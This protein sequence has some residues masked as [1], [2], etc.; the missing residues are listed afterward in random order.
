MVGRAVIRTPFPSAGAG[1]ADG[2]SLCTAASRRR[3]R[4]TASGLI[5]T[6][7]SPSASVEQ[8]EGHAARL[9][10]ALAADAE[11]GV[12][13]VDRR[14]ILNWSTQGALAI[15]T[16][17]SSA[18]SSSRSTRSTSS[19]SYGSHG[20]HALDA[21]SPAQGR[22]VHR[23]RGLAQQGL[24]GAGVLLAAGHGRGAVV[25]DD[26]ERLAA[27]VDHVHEGGDPGVEE[28]AVADDADGLVA[29]SGLRALGRR[30]HDL[31]HAVG[32]ADA[33]AHAGAGSAPRCTAAARPWCSSR[34][35]RSR[36]PAAS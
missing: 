35:R 4:C 15:T 26:G 16:E 31:G 29:Q 11:L 17:A 5:S 24:A 13:L 20:G 25:D 28:G 32:H 19:R 9:Q 33:G 8:V 14:L 34:C 7:R 36:T 2:V 27:V 30:F 6:L 1:R 23:G 21:Q 18:S 12:D 22:D 3:S 10:A